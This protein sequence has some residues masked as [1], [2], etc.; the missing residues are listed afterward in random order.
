MTTEKKAEYQI[1]DLMELIETEM[2]GLD[3]DK[4]YDEDDNSLTEEYIRNK[5]EEIYNDLGKTHGKII[6]LQFELRK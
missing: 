1:S 2:N 4:E 3:P 6:D 5:W